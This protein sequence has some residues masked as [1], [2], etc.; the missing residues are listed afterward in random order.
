M[1]ALKGKKKIRVR[2]LVLECLHVRAYLILSTAWEVES[3]NLNLHIRLI[4]QWSSINLREVTCSR[5][6]TGNNVRA[7]TSNL[8][9]VTAKPLHSHYSRLLDAIVEES[10]FYSEGNEDLKDFKRK[11]N[12]VKLAFWKGSF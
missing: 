10:G 6:H 7:G 9:H 4:Y 8:A 1:R 12:M 3:S 2:L 5:F 11:T